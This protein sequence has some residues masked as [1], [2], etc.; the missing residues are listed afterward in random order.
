MSNIPYPLP[1][2][3][4]PPLGHVAIRFNPN[5]MH[6]L[7]AELCEREREVHGLGQHEHIDFIPQRAV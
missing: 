1:R 4:R 5:D 2:G 7:I 6:P 3:P